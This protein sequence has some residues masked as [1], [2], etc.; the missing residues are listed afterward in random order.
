[1]VNS[2]R[3]SPYLPPYPFPSRFSRI[4]D[5]TRAERGNKCQNRK[6]E[7]AVRGILFVEQNRVRICR[8]NAI[9]GTPRLKLLNYRARNIDACLTLSL[10]SQLNC[11]GRMMVECNSVSFGV[12]TSMSI[13]SRP[14]VSRFVVFV[15]R[16]IVGLATNSRHSLRKGCSYGVSRSLYRGPNG[17]E[18]NG[19]RERY[20][21]GKRIESDRVNAVSCIRVYAIRICI[22]GLLL[23]RLQRAPPVSRGIYIGSV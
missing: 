18:D 7:I 2:R 17:A 22:V 9:V 1:M 21:T 19:R 5:C 23:K 13:T 20:V 10:E 8:R 6:R 11:V 16:R 15:R 3:A 4:T 12:R 14:G